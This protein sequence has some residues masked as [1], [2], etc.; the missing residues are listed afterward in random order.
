MCVPAIGLN[1]IRTS[2]DKKRVLLG[3]FDFMREFIVPRSL[4]F[5]IIILLCYSFRRIENAYFIYYMHMRVCK[6]YIS[7]TDDTAICVC[8][9]GT[10][11]IL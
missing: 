4:F 2:M 1:D 6:Y 11:K 8:I 10:E 9:C 5:G 7:E 3:D